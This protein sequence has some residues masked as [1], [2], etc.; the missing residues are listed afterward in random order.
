[1]P[2]GPDTN[3]RGEARAN[4]FFA[5]GTEGV[6]FR[7]NTPFFDPP[8]KEP[9]TEQQER[10]FPPPPPPPQVQSFA[11]EMAQEEAHA[12]ELDRRKQKHFDR[13]DKEHKANMDAWHKQQSRDR[14]RFGDGP[15]PPNPVPQKSTLPPPPPPP[16]EAPYRDKPSDADRV[17]HG[18]PPPPPREKKKTPPPPEYPG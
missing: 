15:R 6:P 3:R 12:P 2:I 18:P 11:S 13:I 17:K 8:E 10:E 9:E 7:R 16:W 1:M 14:K 5:A 4:R